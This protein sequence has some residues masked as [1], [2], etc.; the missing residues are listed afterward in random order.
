MQAKG[1]NLFAQII[2]LVDRDEF[3]RLV[4]KFGNDKH[5][6]GFSTWD[7][8]VSMLFCHLGKAQS[9]REICGGLATCMGKLLHLRMQEA[10][11]RST[12]SYANAHRDYRLFE[13][14]YYLILE[15]CQK[16]CQGKRKFRFR[17]KVFSVDATVIELCLTMFNW[18][19]YRQ[20]KGAVKLHC[21]LDHDGY[22]P[23]FACI[24]EGKPHD[25]KIAKRAIFPSFP[26]PA[27]S[28]VVIDLGYYDFKLFATWCATG[29][30]F[31]TRMKTNADYV[32][33]ERY[34]PPKNRNVLKDERIRLNGFSSQQNCPYDLRRIESWNEERQEID[35][36]LTNNLDL[37]STTI[38]A[39]HKD[40][41]QIEMFF[42]ALKQHLKVKTFVGTSPNALKIQLWTALIA[43]LLLKYLKMLSTFNWSLSNLIAMLRFNLFTYRDLLEWLNAPFDCLIEEPH[44][45]QLELPFGQH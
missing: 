19:T 41:W 17:N 9:L 6:K 32:V 34:D 24:S 30:F 37:G 22:L 2:A 16:Q 8:L 18:A 15:K 20:T 27:G 13:E 40:R 11:K 25:L 36:F 42:K 45:A 7:Q 35:V 21:I 28:I 5:S 38:A 39:I 4:R 44:A 3:N 12:L 23:T 26:F 29:V 31:V 14:L 43:M 10:P 33:V 1:T